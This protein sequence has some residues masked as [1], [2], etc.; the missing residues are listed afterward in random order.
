MTYQNFY[1][2]CINL[3]DRHPG[4]P[5]VAYLALDG[6]DQRK[7]NIAAN[8]WMQTLDLAYR[9]NDPRQVGFRELVEKSYSSPIATGY[10]P[11]N[12][13]LH[14]CA[15]ADYDEIQKARAAELE[16]AEEAATLAA[17]FGHE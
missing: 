15:R 7:I 17:V 5:L 12:T 6:D 8:A 16:H 10:I 13:V 2:A 9:A 1:A 3:F 11:K 4:M 14:E